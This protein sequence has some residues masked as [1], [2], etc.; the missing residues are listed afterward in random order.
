MWHRWRHLCEGSGGA[1][2]KAKRASVRVKRPPDE[3]SGFVPRFK[4][5]AQHQA[6]EAVDYFM[7]S[8][9]GAGF[10]WNPTPK[11]NGGDEVLDLRAALEMMGRDLC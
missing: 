3:N 1:R 8:R 5:R 10:F 9:R 2:G 6:F 7:Y 4:P 11:L